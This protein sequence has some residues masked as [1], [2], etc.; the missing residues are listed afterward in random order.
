MTG[1]KLT[2][3]FRG[4]RPLGWF[5]IIRL[6]D[7]PSSGILALLKLDHAALVVPGNLKSGW[8]FL[9]CHVPL[10]PLDCF[11]QLL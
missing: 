3:N 10:R 9:A 1:V 7:T 4:L 5:L 2:N 8:Q 6:T 11:T